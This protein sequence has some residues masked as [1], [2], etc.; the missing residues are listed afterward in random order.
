MCIDYKSLSDMTIKDKFPI[1]AI[2]ELFDELYGSRWYS[3]FDLR[4]GYHQ[5]RV[6]KPDISKAA[7]KT[8]TCHFEFLVMPFGLTNAPSIVDIRNFVYIF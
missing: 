7:F 4:S 8:N 2:D 3:K 6:H 5:I 1:P